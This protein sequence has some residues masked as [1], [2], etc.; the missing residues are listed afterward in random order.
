M[1]AAQIIDWTNRRES[2]SKVSRKKTASKTIMCIHKWVI[3][4]MIEK[5]TA[6]DIPWL[7]ETIEDCRAHCIVPQNNTLH[8]A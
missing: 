3:S 7:M 4:E 2:A 6:K 5:L 8:P 1:R